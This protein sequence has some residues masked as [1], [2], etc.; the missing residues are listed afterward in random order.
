VTGGDSLLHVDVFCTSLT[1]L[2]GGSPRARDWDCCEVDHKLPAVRG[3][4]IPIAFDPLRNTWMASD[5]QQTPTWSKLSSPGYK[6]VTRDFLHARIQTWAPRWNRYINVNGDYMEVWC[7]PSS[8]HISCVQW[9]QNNSRY[10]R[11]C[12]LIC[13]KRPRKQDCKQDFAFRTEKGC[14]PKTIVDYSI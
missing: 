4:V 2:P 12:C 6:R 13:F 8:A 10:Q 14:V 1:S 9:G 3:P 5:L 7:V 11:V